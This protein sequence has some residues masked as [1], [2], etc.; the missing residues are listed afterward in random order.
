[1]NITALAEWALKLFIFATW[2]MEK[3]INQILFPLFSILMVNTD[4]KFTIGVID[5]GGNLPQVSLIPMAHLDLQISPRIFENV[6][7]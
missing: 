7:K 3:I 1:L 6:L 2:Q 5:T 4:G